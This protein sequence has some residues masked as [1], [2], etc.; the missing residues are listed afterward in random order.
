MRKSLTAPPEVK[1]YAQ[2]HH[3]ADQ[4]GR[5]A[6]SIAEAAKVAG[7]STDQLGPAGVIGG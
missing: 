1:S 7:L 5:H 2:I 3:I 4:Y 6:I